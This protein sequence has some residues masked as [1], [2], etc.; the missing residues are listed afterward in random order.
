MNILLTLL[1]TILSTNS[2]AFDQESVQKRI[3]EEMERLAKN[4]DHTQSRPKYSGNLAQIDAEE[5]KEED[6]EFTPLNLESAFGVMEDKIKTRQAA[7]AKKLKKRSAIPQTS[8]G[9]IFSKD[10]DE[11]LK[12][13][14]GNKIKTK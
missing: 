7:P 9:D 14:S 4:L 6:A 11:D 13:E 12:D 2:Q 10:L 3:K 1:F 5:A 8:A